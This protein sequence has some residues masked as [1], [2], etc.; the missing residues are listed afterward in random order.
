MAGTT[1]GTV[2]QLKDIKLDALNHILRTVQTEFDRLAGLSGDVRFRDRV[3]TPVLRATGTAGAPSLHVV[4]GYGLLDRYAAVPTFEFQRANGTLA[5]PSQVL[6]GETLGS[7]HFRGYH[8]TGGGGAFPTTNSATIQAVAAET[9]TS[10]A[11]GGHL[12]LQTTPIGSTTSAERIRITEAGNVGIGT[13]TPAATLHIASGYGLV[14]RYAAAP[15]LTLQRAN[16]TLAAPSQV[17]SGETLG[18]LHFGGYHSGGAF[19]ATNSATVRGLAAENFTSTAQGGHLSFRT[20]PVG[21]TT[22]AERVRITERGDVGIGTTTP[23]FASSAGRNY[24]SLIGSTSLG[25]LELATNAADADGVG[26]GQVM[27]IDV[28]NS[29]GGAQQRSAGIQGI[30]SGTTALNR[31]GDLQFFTKADGGSGIAERMRITEAGNVGIGTASPAASA[32]VDMT[33]TTGALLVPRM[34]TTQR[35]ALTAVNGMIVYNSTTGAFNGRA[36]G[37]WVAL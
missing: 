16:G 20:T 13:T 2:F 15:M 32:L 11:Q 25:V 29:G 8:S 19:P 28:L 30:L 14:D 5:A 36:A 37:A 26:L 22:I 24:L 33:S 35:D 1:T 6:S 23:G 3:E 9:Y 18:A 34:T 21:S 17:L 7:L 12:T 27:F 10:T 4:E 31:G